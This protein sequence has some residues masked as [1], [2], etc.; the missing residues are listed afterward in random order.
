MAPTDFIKWM[1]LPNG[2]PP[3]LDYYGHNP[4]S[5]RFPKLSKTPYHQG[6]LAKRYKY[7]RPGIEDT[8]WG[9]REVTVQDGFGNKLIF[10]RDLPRS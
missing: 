4:F 2:L 9:T 10:Y 3:R 1:K 7:Y 8:E 6:L 5:L